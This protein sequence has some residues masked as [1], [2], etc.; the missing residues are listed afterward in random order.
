MK[1]ILGEGL[2]Q[3]MLSQ[4]TTIHPEILGHL[5]W[6]PDWIKPQIPTHKTF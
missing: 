2:V 5:H 3:M 6:L 4:K 1:L